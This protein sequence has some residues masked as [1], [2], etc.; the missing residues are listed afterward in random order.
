[1]KEKGY[2]HCWLLPLNGLQ[3]G[4]PY[5]GRLVG[6]ANDSEGNNKLDETKRV[7]TLLVASP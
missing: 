4:T 1:M 5:A 7:L 3:D 2:L 6:S